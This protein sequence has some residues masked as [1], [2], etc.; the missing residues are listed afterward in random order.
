M[1]EISKITELIWIPTRGFWAA[2]ES[3]MLP[4]AHK[5]W[6]IQIAW[7]LNYCRNEL[8]AWRIVKQKFWSRLSQ[9]RA[10]NSGFSAL[11]SLKIFFSPKKKF[12]SFVSIFYT[13]KNFY[14]KN[15]DPQLESYLYNIAYGTKAF[16][17]KSALVNPLICII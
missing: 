13:Q 5:C 4:S 6:V 11:E 3:R 8:F 17:Y 10:W 7:D 12:V 15:G 9:K 16:C 2:L 1:F 14:G